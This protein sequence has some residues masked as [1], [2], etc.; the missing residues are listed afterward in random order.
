MKESASPTVISVLNQKGGVGKT[1]IATNLA[2][3]LILKGF[4]VLLVDGDPQGSARD[5]HAANNAE[6][7]P[8]VGLDR[9]TIPSDLKAV[10]LGYDVIIIDGAPQIARLSAAAIRASDVVLIPVQPSPYDV[11][12]TGDLVDL[13]KERQLVTDG[14]PQASFIINRMIRNTILSRDV[15]GVLS[16]YGFPVLDAKTCQYVAYANSA[17]SGHSVFCSGYAA[18]ATEFGLLVEEVISKYLPTKKLKYKD[19]KIEENLDITI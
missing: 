16:E 18:V 15:V 1:T 9:E 14:K 7:V 8:C 13:I 17:S 10:S 2:H 5:W 4:K 3:G 12:A 11:W 19:M 6:L